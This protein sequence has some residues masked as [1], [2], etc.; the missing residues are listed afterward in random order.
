MRREKLLAASK[1]TFIGMT[2]T[3]NVMDFVSSWVTCQQT[4]YC[5]KPPLD[6][7]QPIPPPSTVSE[8]ITMDLIVNLPALQGHTIILVVVDCFSKAAHSKTLPTN[9]FAYKAAETSLR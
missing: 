2:C 5:P 6:Q 8:D 1:P 3:N 4:K 7:L 9:F